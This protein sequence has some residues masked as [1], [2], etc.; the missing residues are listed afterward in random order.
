MFYIDLDFQNSVKK[1]RKP[2]LSPPSFK[3][4]IRNTK[5]AG[6]VV[7]V[8]HV[9]VGHNFSDSRH[10]VRGTIAEKN[11]KGRFARE[12]CNSCYFLCKIMLA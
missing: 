5:V 10:E 7:K 3:H 1:S 4:T 2:D 8:G 11:D 9:Y 12:P 6:G